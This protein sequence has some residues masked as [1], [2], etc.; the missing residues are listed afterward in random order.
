MR[1]FPP[2]PALTCWLPRRGDFTLTVA[3]GVQLT[4]CEADRSRTLYF[5]NAAMAY[6][7]TSRHVVLDAPCR[8]LRVVGTP[9]RWK[10]S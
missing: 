4:Y 7:R 9:P 6:G 10:C 2:H 5:T 1:P 3:D 8:R